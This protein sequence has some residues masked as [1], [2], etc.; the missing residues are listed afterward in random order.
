MASLS[1]IQNNYEMIQGDDKFK[2]RTER[3]E[4]SK[5][6]NQKD[7]TLDIKANR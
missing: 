1:N 7:G 3:S 6:E 2:T 5:F 4:V